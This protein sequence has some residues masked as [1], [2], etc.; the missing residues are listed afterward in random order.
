MMAC[1]LLTFV[2]FEDL[3]STN[4]MNRIFEDE[5]SHV[6]FGYNWL[7]K[8]KSHE[9]SAY[10]DWLDS[11]SPLMGPRRAR[12]KILHEDGRHLAGIDKNWIEKLSQA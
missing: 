3:G 11:L 5:I 10:D 6:S 4:L 7:K 9:K 12:G 2:S 1:T 8:F